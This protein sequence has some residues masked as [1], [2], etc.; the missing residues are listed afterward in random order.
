VIHSDY[1]SFKHLKGQ[2][3]LNRRHDNWVEFIETFLH[4]I[5]YKQG[6]EN[7]VV[8]ALSRRYVLL[9][10]FDARFFG[11][12]H[13]KEL[14]KDDSDFTNVYNACG[15]STFGKFYRLDGYLFKENLLCVPLNFMHELLVHEV[16]GGELIGHF[17][18]IK[19][20]DMLHDHFYWL[21]IK[22]DMQRICDKCITYRKAKFKTQPYSLNTL[23]PVPKELWLD[24]SM[25]FFILGMPRS[26]QGRN[27]IFVVIDRFSKMAHFIPCHKTDDETNIDNLFF[28]EILRLH[29]VPYIIISNRDD[30]FLNY[31]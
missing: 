26:K 30:K 27:S 23:F 7:I 21:K 24:I 17:G 14:Y 9:S 31:F 8:D 10:T 11:F 13:I 4:V 2:G 20:L 5:K 28:R 25:D 3:K 29:R 16:D 1:E 6:Q 19:T 22:N 15:T 18:V 12:E